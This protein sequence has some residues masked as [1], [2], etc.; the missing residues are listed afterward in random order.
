MAFMEFGESFYGVWCEVLF[1]VLGESFMAFG[2]R[3]LFEVLGESFYGMPSMVLMY[4]LFSSSSGK[5]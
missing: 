3:F 5:L 1:E 2:V 4:C